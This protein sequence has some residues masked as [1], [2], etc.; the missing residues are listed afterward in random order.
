MTTALRIAPETLGLVIARAMALGA[1]NRR[2]A[3]G[4]VPA[5][6][7]ATDREVEWLCGTDADRF[8]ILEDRA[9][10]LD[11]TLA[12]LHDDHLAE[13]VALAWVG[14]GTF[15]REDWT[16]ALMSARSLD[17]DAA[18]A[19]LMQTCGLD[20]ALRTG[21]QQLRHPEPRGRPLAAAA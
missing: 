6:D 20:E 12:G 10:V 17:A 4:P 16:I 18:R 19:H 15:G 2:R 7:D 1:E 21:L 8:L 13:L 3:G 11:H 5:D 9:D 14:E